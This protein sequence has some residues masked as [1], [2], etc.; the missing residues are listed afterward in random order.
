MEKKQ[1]KYTADFREFVAKMVIK[2]GKKII[3]LSNELDVPYDTLSKWVYRYRQKEKEAEQNAQSKLL[4]ASEYK[5]M[6]E[7]EKRRRL[8]FEEEIDILK[9]AMHIFTQEKN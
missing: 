1:K 4:T 3:D 9:K 5:D 8:E 6:Y 2:D 7:E